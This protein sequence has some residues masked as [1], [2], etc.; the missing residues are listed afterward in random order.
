MW[1]SVLDIFEKHTLLNKLAAR[2]SFYTATILESENVLT[3]ANRIRQ[4]ASTL[5][6]MKVTIDDEEM[7]MALLNGL[8]ERF[9]SLMSELD[10]LGDKKTFIF[11]SLRAAYFRKNKEISNELKPPSKIL[12]RVR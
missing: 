7:A 3:F 1:E 6:S 8:P 11:G 4:L 2:R 9:D 12:K 10:A 5:K